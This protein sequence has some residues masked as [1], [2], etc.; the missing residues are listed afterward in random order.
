[1]L[2]ARVFW[3]LCLLGGLLSCSTMTT[4]SNYDDTVN[5]AAYTSFS[6]LEPSPP[7]QLNA[8]QALAK[9]WIHEAVEESL[10]AKGF[11]KTA[12]GA[13]DLQLIYVADVKKKHEVTRDSET[14]FYRHYGM[15]QSRTIEM[16][17]IRNYQ[18]GVLSIG[19][20]A[21]GH[22]GLIWYG[23]ASTEVGS[24]KDDKDIIRKAVGK[25]LAEFPP[26]TLPVDS[27]GPSGA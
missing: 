5:F 7:R 24:P 2:S 13:S 16:I 27:H 10:V 6:W 26:P 12:A 4:S 11:R 17:H 20:V 8:Y 21:P 25:I 3:S 15:L 1:M 18:E 23:G 22:Q 14:Y 9:E 19:M